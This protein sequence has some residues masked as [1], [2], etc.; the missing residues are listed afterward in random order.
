[1]KNHSKTSAAAFPFYKKSFPIERKF[2]VK[3]C[4]SFSV[5]C[6]YAI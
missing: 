3:T 6:F 5:Q 2:A 1:M 4:V